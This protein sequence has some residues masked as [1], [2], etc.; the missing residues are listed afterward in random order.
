MRSVYIDC[1]P[2]VRDQMNADIRG[3][4]PDLAIHLGDPDA[5]TL[6]ALLDGA[7]AAVNG[8]TAMDATLLAML[9]AL[10]SIVFLGS[11]PASYIDIAAA[12]RCGIRVRAV[13]HYGD[14]SVAEHGFA[15][16]LAAARRLAEMDRDLRCGRWDPLDGIELAGKTLGVVGTGGIG[17]EMVR[18]A[19][20][21]GMHV[22]AWNR[23]GVA[24]DLPCRAVELDELLRRA[25][26]VSLHLALGEATR[27][28]MD[29][30]RL[31]LLRP[32]A[33]LVNTARAALIDEAALIAALAARRIGHAALD[34]YATEP[35]PAGHPLTRLDNV[36][37]SAHAG[38]KTPEATQRLI[39]RGLGLLRQ[40][41]DTLA[42]GADLPR[43]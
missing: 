36:T 6:A 20:G 27:G 16:I 22:I 39:A 14:R 34:V 12:E 31:A 35:L 8:H 5:P 28:L 19:H 42:A 26:V 41:L 9:P 24:A 3:L 10:R 40:D 7:A 23:S 25:D 18:I 43:S 21:F 1:T 29:A 37:L 15:L 2:F 11:G 32:G 33:I 38:F 4:V 30:R 17:R 13:A